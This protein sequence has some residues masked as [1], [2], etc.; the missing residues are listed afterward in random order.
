MKRA[1]LEEKLPVLVKDPENQH[2]KGPFQSITWGRGYACVS[3]PSSP[4][5]IPRKIL[6]ELMEEQLAKGN[7]IKTNSPW[8]SLVFVI[9]KPGKDKW[10]ILHDL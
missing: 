3:T 1:Q 2:V 5:W 7:I 9:K 10:H 6:E 8:N 4:K